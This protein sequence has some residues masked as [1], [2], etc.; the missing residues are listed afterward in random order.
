[1]N[2]RRQGVA[3]SVLDLAGLGV[4]SGTE[5]ARRRLALFI[6]G[7]IAPASIVAGWW[8][9]PH[10]LRT[11][12]IR[13]ALVAAIVVFVA[14]RRRPTRAEWV[15]VLAVVPLTASTFSTWQAGPRGDD[16]FVLNMVA[17]IAA[18]A[19]VGDGLVACT[20]LGLGICELAATQFHLDPVSRAVATTIAGGATMIALTLVV[21]AT[22][23]RLRESVA[24]LARSAA[25]VDEAYVAQAL[26]LE[27]L[28]GALI[29]YDAERGEMLYASPHIEDL[30]GEPAEA[31]LGRDGFERWGNAMTD[32]SVADWRARG[33]SG[34]SWQNHYRFRR[35]DGGLR[36]FQSVSRPVS[37]A[38]VQTI[39]F[40]TTAEVEASSALEAEHQRYQTLIEQMPAVTV[41]NAP[42]GN[43][44]YVSPQIEEM[45]GYSP[46]EFIE[47]MNAE[48][49]IELVHPDDRARVLESM[50]AVA[51][52]R[53]PNIELEVR[54][55]ARG[56]DYR[57]VLIRRAR[58]ADPDGTPYLQTVG[59]DVTDLRDAQRRSR[60]AL[61]ALVHAGEEAQARVATELHDDT[62]QALTAIHY[63]LEALGDGDG[64]LAKV[65]ADLAATTE[66]ARTLMFELRPRMLDR[67]G[68][69]PAI[70]EVARDGPWATSRIS[71]TIDR[72]APTLEAL[73]YRT[74]RELIVN[75]RKHS[76]AHT[77][78][79]T[80]RQENGTLVFDVDDD[81]VGFDPARLGGDGAHRHIGLETTIERLRLAQGELTIDAAPGNGTH[82][83]ITVPA[84][85]RTGEMC[86]PPDLVDPSD[87]W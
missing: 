64:R 24:D 44:E 11:T 14:L 38:I 36:W 83:H 3:V 79:V 48:D 74:L 21:F 9:Y 43:V 80:G 30:T 60:S 62:I 61:E 6:F 82:V 41:R 72:Q 34:A 65:V 40:D 46:A 77:L 28:P 18:V 51:E 23:S 20:A 37:P 47:R 19:V 69:E 25:A 78:T 56:G 2:T 22:A 57:D 70:A 4:S 84:E 10:P 55:R 86:H 81:G 68:L 35:R 1:V 13:A 59:L 16:L 50:R 85:P 42:D 73:C 12:L 71:I 29:Q 26:L 33:R 5:A 87:R 39:V 15:I 53:L 63:R 45:L 31:W 54:M 52:E 7:V 49:W 67:E 17:M 66:R 27:R 76:Q 75:A 32:P 8:L 58:V